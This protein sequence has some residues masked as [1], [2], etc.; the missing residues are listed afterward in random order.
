MHYTPGLLKT[1]QGN[2]S[3]LEKIHTSLEEYLE[4]KRLAFP[5]LYFLS[6]D[7]LLEILTHTRNPMAQVQVL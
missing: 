7:E 2:N 3:V 1:F 6:N 5:H 4:A